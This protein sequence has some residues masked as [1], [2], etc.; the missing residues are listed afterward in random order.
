[1]TKLQPGQ[2][3]PI[4]RVGESVR[5]A[6]SAP[7]ISVGYGI[8]LVPLNAS[9]VGMPGA[10]Q[11]YG[12]E[13]AWVRDEGATVTIDFAQVPA[14]TNKLLVCLYSIRSARSLRDVPE[15][16]LT[17]G[18]HEIALRGAD[19]PHA[20]AC[21]ILAELYRRDNAWKIRARSDGLIDGIDALGRRYGVTLSDD[22][23]NA[24]RE[25]GFDQ[26]D[27]RQQEQP[28]QD[29]GSPNG[30]PQWTGSGFSVARRLIVTNAHVVDEARVITVSG[31]DGTSRAKPVIVDRNNDVALIRTEQDLDGP[32]LPF[33]F[34]GGP[35]LGETVAV[36]GYPLAGLLSSGPQVTT[37]GISSLLGPQEDARQLQLS[38][39]IQPGSS[40]GPLLDMRGRVIGVVVAT[41]TN[42]QN[43][44]FA[45]RASLAE[46][47]IEA[48]GEDCTRLDDPTP[49]TPALDLQ[50]LVKTVRKS[51]W[52]LEIHQ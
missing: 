3:A 6:F 11:S 48:A 28:R 17:A 2:N 43:V 18:E 32:P 4:A 33:R 40:G 37:G 12:G 31:Y 45:V 42:A 19:F 38:A 49:G 39:A 21:A 25:F 13:S 30:R 36:L 9:D 10:F 27:R 35:G 15:I 26:S 51:V 50:S 14:S 22:G 47:L 34:R 41:L 24:P 52:R 46:A 29:Y 23:P 8:A 16:R 20:Y 1:M 5:L 7:R 44:N